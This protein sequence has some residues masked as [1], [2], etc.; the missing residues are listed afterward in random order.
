MPV[1]L[2]DVLQMTRIDCVRFSVPSATWDEWRKIAML[3]YVRV[4]WRI[5]KDAHR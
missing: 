4:V 3:G 1:V 2:A 5:R